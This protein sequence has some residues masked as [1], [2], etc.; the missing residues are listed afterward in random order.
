MDFNSRLL[1]LARL[2]A[3]TRDANEQLT[4]LR[5]RLFERYIAPL[6][7]AIE[8]NE[9]RLEEAVATLKAD[10]LRYVAETGDLTPHPSL[11]FRRTTKLL[12][13]KDAALRAAEDHG[14]SNFVRVKK[15]LNVRDFESAWRR[16]LLPW[17]EVE[18][19]PA[20]TVALGRLGDL[21]ILAE[22]KR[23]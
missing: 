14:A 8:I 18:E 13:D 16:G 2:E 15:E 17:A 5:D 19:V 23:A 10:T 4:A 12:Y 7:A 20:P 1:E 22:E 3:T 21:L 6:D 11:T 9:D